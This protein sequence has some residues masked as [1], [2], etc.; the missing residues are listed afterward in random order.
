MRKFKLLAPAIL[1][2]AACNN[3]PATTETT[4]SDTT[5]ASANVVT[6]DT[7]TQPGYDPA[8]DG[9]LV[10]AQFSKKLADT[11]NVKMYEISLKPGDTATLHSHPDHAVYVLQGGKLAVYFGG[12]NRV[13]MDLPTGGG[14]VSGPV[15]DAAKNIGKTNIKLLIVDMYRPRGNKNINAK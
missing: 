3:T 13:E 11:L 6:G 15:D 2:I 5:P 1:F 4:N 9:L 12:T 8:K 10:G 7:T 14:F